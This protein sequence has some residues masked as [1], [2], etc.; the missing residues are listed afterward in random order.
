MI[1]NTLLLLSAIL[2]LSGC[3]TP[4]PLAY[5]ISTESYRGNHRSAV[6]QF[7]Q[8][9][10]EF[11]HWADYEPKEWEQHWGHMIYLCNSYQMLRDFSKA[12]QCVLLWKEEMLK[13][14]GDSQEDQE[15]KK[16]ILVNYNLVNSAASLELANYQEAYRSYKLARAYSSLNE[17]NCTMPLE[18]GIG[19][20]DMARMY[21]NG[22]VAAVQLGYRDEAA[23]I[24]EEIDCITWSSIVVNEAAKDVKVKNASKARIYLALGDY[25]KAQEAMLFSQSLG[26]TFFRSM[27]ALTTLGF[28]EL[29]GEGKKTANPFNFDETYMLAKI[30]Q[31]RGQLKDAENIY[32]SLLYTAEQSDTPIVQIYNNLIFDPEQATNHSPALLNR[33]GIYYQLLY[34]LG[35][36]A[37]QLGRPSEAL[38][39][40]KQS[41]EVIEEQRSTINT[42]ASKIGFI[43]NK[44]AV[45]Q[46]LVS[47]LIK[48]GKLEQAFIY[49]E[50]SKARALIDTL[51]S[52]Q[53]FSPKNVDERPPMLLA[54]LNKID[55]DL[56]TADYSEAS[57]RSRS[58]DRGLLRKTQ[59]QLQTAQPELASLVTVSA[60][61]VAEL[62][63]RLAGDE[64]LIEFYG[65][66]TQLFAF[67]L[68]RSGIKA[69]VLNG[70]DL[71]AAVSALRDDLQK[72]DSNAYQ[73]NANLLYQRLF[74]PLK[75]ELHTEKLIIVPHGPLHYLPFNALY[76]GSDFLIDQYDISI[77]PSASV[78]AFLNKRTTATQPLLVLG[79]PELGDAKLAL[80]GAEQEAKAIASQQPGATLLLGADATETQI[81]QHGALFKVL[82]FASHGIFN[83]QT[84][85]SSGLLLAKDKSNDGILTV[86]ELYELNLNADLVTLSACETGLGK[87]ANGDDVVGF[88]RGFLYAGTNS[89]ISSLWKV[90]DQATSQLMQHFYANLVNSSDKR[91]ALKKAQLAVKADYNRHPY[92]WAAFQLTGR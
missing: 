22:A 49:A 33:Q 1:K 3:S 13:Q 67:L 31:G 66:G 5:Q 68:S 91:L 44:E 92:Y 54:Q 39:Y 81:K 51:A 88:T 76:N 57:G 84:P 17:N 48:Q 18:K 83:P 72:N 16:W 45:Y 21:A 59:Q 4:M 50:R 20:E 11:E 75:D 6:E 58:A 36:I 82:H 70:E 61:E 87:I 40:Y 53:D 77:L 14:L 41:V 78:M 12:Q 29:L 90:D 28:S 26:D 7:S 65:S 19:I 34:A 32:L 9:I 73:H 10:G 63:Q 42:E 30:A 62:Q 8:E 69:A 25:S 80:P 79:N 55:S 85:L 23:A 60:P 64:T 27:D 43:G 2:A 56:K 74:K 46:D 47:L 24:A 71:A 35:V 15:N 89:I 38:N 37:E 52:K 86:R